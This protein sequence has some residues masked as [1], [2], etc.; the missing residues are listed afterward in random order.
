MW[1]NFLLIAG[2]TASP[3]LAQ[4]Y[5]YVRPGAPPLRPLPPPPSWQITPPPPLSGT[6][7]PR[8]TKATK[9]TQ[10]VKPVKPV[11]KPT[12]KAQPLPLSTM[13]RSTP[14]DLL[15]PVEV[16]A[17]RERILEVSFDRFSNPTA[18]LL[19][20]AEGLTKTLNLQPKPSFPSNEPGVSILE[21]VLFPGYGGA[22]Q[23]QG[24]VKLIQSGGPI[25][26]Q[27]ALESFATQAQ[28]ELGSWPYSIKRPVRYRITVD[29]K[30]QR[31]I[32]TLEEI[33]YG[34]T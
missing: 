24:A 29:G 13:E 12:V 19:T 21:V 11:L 14:L 16:N 15:A 6:F 7:K 28:T 30:T 5:E 1:R 3:V 18:A 2:L 27:V 34:K 10:P 8:R 31:F 22:V 4:G 9:A 25:L 23:V 32:C 33:I 26:D 17:L 20:Y